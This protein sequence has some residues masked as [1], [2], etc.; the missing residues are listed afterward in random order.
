MNFSGNV[1]LTIS[2]A[3]SPL[4]RSAMKRATDN[5]QS[6]GSDHVPTKWDLRKQA[7]G[8]SLLNPDLDQH[9]PT[10]MQAMKIIQ[11]FPS[12]HMKKGKR[13]R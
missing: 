1:S 6:D 2:S 3:T 4:C 9:C 8:Q 7:V 10:E 5:I 13:N 11:N 12:S